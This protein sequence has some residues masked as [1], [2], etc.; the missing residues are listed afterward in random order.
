MLLPSLAVNT[1]DWMDGMESMQ[2]RSVRLSVTIG[3]LVG[4][5]TFGGE[6]ILNFGKRQ[7]G[8]NCELS[9]DG[10]RTC[11][12]GVCRLSGPRAFRV[13]YGG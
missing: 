13:A 4:K 7:L 12:V 6:G 8:W 11:T 5:A 9:L 2:T 3:S 1:G 10:G